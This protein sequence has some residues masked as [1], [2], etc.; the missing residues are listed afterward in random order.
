MD[1]HNTQCTVI[2]KKVQRER[3]LKIISRLI[4]AIY[5]CKMRQI[6]MKWNPHVP[7][8]TSKQVMS[9]HNADLA[10]GRQR[11]MATG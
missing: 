3:R 6:R 9:S 2:I 8:A 5:S 7:D 11:R 4:K 1:W 10:T